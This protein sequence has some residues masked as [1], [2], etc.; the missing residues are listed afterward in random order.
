MLEKLQQYMKS[1]QVLT[2]IASLVLVWAI[3]NYSGN[4]SM[5]PEYMS[6]GSGSGSGSGSNRRNKGNRNGSGSGGVPMPVDDSSVYNQLDSVAASASSTTGLPPNCSGQANINPAD[7][8]PKDNN[9]SWN[10]KPMGSGDFLG[11]NLLNAGYLIGVD[12]IGSSLRNANL[13]VR[14]EPPNPQLQVSPW[15]NTT[16]EPDPF[17]APLEIGCGPKPC[18]K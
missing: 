18:S 16:I 6:N 5:F 1:H 9:S 2:I 7:L 14:S 4:K 10:M 12:T 3:Y 17:R 11:V 13:Q 15:M 8:L